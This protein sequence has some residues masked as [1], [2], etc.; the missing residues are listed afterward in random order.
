MKF[1]LETLQSMYND[2][3]EEVR[4]N[5]NE[6]TFHRINKIHYQKRVLK[7]KVFMTNYINFNIDE[8]CLLQRKM[9]E[10]IN[11][12]TKELT[13]KVVGLEGKLHKMTHENSKLK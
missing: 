3:L 2:C 11:S 5:S 8:I 1:E 9:D 12:V 10:K 4:I 6:L 13:R 7:G